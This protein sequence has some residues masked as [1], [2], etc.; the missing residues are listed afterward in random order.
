MR[1]I[2]L[3]ALIAFTILGCSKE[4]K[5]LDTNPLEGEWNVESVSCMCSPINLEVGEHIWTFDLINYKVDVV[6]NI[7]EILHTLPETGNYE[8]SIDDNEI[9]VRGRNYNY[10]L[11]MI[12]YI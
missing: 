9:T 5:E 4:D 8:I 6:S 10:F 12:N 3:L 2:I 7:D 1:Q 11:K